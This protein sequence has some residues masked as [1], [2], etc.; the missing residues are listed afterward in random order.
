MIREGRSRRILTLSCKE[1]IVTPPLSRTAFHSFCAA[2]WERGH[3]ESGILCLG[4]S[5]LRWNSTVLRLVAG[6][7][8]K[9]TAA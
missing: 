2:A 6:S 8:P 4:I 1:I 9:A 3:S 7:F 5:V